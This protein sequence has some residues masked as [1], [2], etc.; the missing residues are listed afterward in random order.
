M[1]ED[2]VKTIQHLMDLGIGEVQRLD[3]ILTSIKA[4]GDKSSESLVGIDYPITKQE[5]IDKMVF[6]IPQGGYATKLVTGKLILITVAVI[7]GIGIVQHV[8]YHKKN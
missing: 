3:H 1:S 4:K 7:V 5:Y 8:L 2:L 6:T